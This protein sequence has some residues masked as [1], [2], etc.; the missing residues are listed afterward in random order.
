MLFDGD[1][2]LLIVIKKQRSDSLCKLYSYVKTGFQKMFTTLPYIK[3]IDKSIKDTVF[4]MIYFSKNGFTFLD[5]EPYVLIE[6]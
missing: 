6:S 1:L 5:Q 4:A 3:V 2:I